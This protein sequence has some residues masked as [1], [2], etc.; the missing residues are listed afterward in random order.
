MPEATAPSPPRYILAP[1]VPTP[2]EV[3]ERMLDLAGVTAADTV[4]DLGC[5]D[6]RIAIAAAQRGARAVG[7]DIEAH[8]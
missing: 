2:P 1:Y 7:V 5:G 3:V 4:Y 8:W 6:G